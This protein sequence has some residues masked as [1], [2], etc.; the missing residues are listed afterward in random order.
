MIIKIAKWLLLLLA[1]K[2][3]AAFVV[4]QFYTDPRRDI[5]ARQQLCRAFNPNVVFIGTSRTL[6]GIEPALF[7]SLNGG[8]T[9]SYNAGLFSLSPY[10][11]IEIAK[12]LL[13]NNPAVKTIYIELSAL[14]YSTVAL[15]PQQVI[16]DAI[17][18][19]RTLAGSPGARFQENAAGFLDGLNTTLFQMLSIAPQVLSVKK[20]L[21]PDND[22]I[23]GQPDLQQNGHQSVAA[24]L[25]KTNERL[26]ANQSA[27]DR[28]F[29]LAGKQAPNAWYI[30]QIHKL[31]DQSRRLGRK[32]VFYYPNSITA[33]EYKI[34]SQVA[35]FLP[36]A[37]LI[38]PP[39]HA[40]RNALFRP[41]N[42]FD[43][44]HLNR[45]GAAIYT[46]YLQSR[47]K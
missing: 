40:L 46:R 36:E 1:F 38:P 37:N 7:D 28:L 9:R 18:R 21:H 42:L 41:E 19:A 6:Y 31:V 35:P 10:S 24:S 8:Q 12:D 16:P 43:P 25:S 23:E 17:F 4:A 39:G 2:M 44:H 14:D 29:A 26:I 5:A 20:A 47:A 22:P 30:S 45:K 34:L 33:G 13:A 11:S 3:A 32:V 27:T 15:P